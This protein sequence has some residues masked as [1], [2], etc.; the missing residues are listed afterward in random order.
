MKWTEHGN[1][2]VDVVLMIPDTLKMKNHTVQLSGFLKELENEL[3]RNYTSRYA[4]VAFGGKTAF[5]Q[6]PHIV[7]NGGKI[8]GSIKN[9]ESTI[10]SM[11]FN[12]QGA[13]S[14]EAVE[15]LAQLP[16][17]PGA[18]KVVIMLST[19]NRETMT[20]APFL[21]A[22]KELNMQ[23]IIFNV[24]GPYFKR[25]EHKDVLGLWKGKAMVKKSLF[26][27]KEKTIGLPANDH[28]RLAEYTK[29]GVFNL[30]AYSQVHG[31]WLRLLKRAMKTTIV[32]QIQEDQTYCRQCVCVPG[33]TVEPLTICRTNR[34]SRCT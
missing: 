15:Y 25:S 14:F 16:F 28:I 26:H 22:K 30:K 34:H 10:A 1:N 32:K 33:L 11:Q 7:T 12:G 23:G 21:K 17:Q 31:N 24:I 3:R 8:F 4:V 18:S 2:N 13:N 9:V 19:Q 20:K 5:L 29:G 6:R 27:S